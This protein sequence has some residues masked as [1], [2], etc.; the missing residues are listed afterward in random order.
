MHNAGVA[1][2]FVVLY[3]IVFAIIFAMA[4]PYMDSKLQH[5]RRKLLIGARIL[6]ILLVAASIGVPIVMIPLLSTNQNGLAFGKIEV[7]P[8]TSD[9]IVLTYQAN[10]LLLDGKDPYGNTNIITAIEDY[11]T[12]NPTSLRQGNFTDIYPYPTE[13]QIDDALTKAKA[14]PDTPPLEFEST[15]SYPAGSFLFRLPFDALGIT[16]QWF[17]LLC[18]LLIVLVIVYSSPKALRLLA[19]VGCLASVMVWYSQLDGGT[20]SL[21]I[22]FILL[23]WILR[24]R[25]WLAA[26]MMGIACSCK[27][28]AW[29][30]IP[31]YL[32][33]FV[34]E[35]SWSKALQ[36][37]AILGATFAII[38]IPFI[39]ANP[40]AWLTGIFAPMLHPLFP[41][42]IGIS[43]FA[44]LT[45]TPV[46][47]II[48]TTL[49]GI[50]FIGALI[51]YYRNCRQAPQTGVLLAIIPL[52]FAWRSMFAYF[53]MIPMLVFGIIAIEEYKNFKPIPHTVCI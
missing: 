45:K 27:Q 40:T 35:V 53:I 36:S 18:T 41:N 1:L 8:A 2:C 46:P 22:L 17:Y 47:Q 49:E 42:G 38:N 44:T 4:K 28:T 11:K 23:G 7:P 13:K 19:L 3:L 29:F 48:F 9:T 37:L 5:H 33:L 6:A 20:E 15:L 21:F 16:P 31:F 26:I 34:R 14:N 51:W 43:A 30:F 12:A 25:P 52:F 24:K 39:V 32:V 10:H 50:T